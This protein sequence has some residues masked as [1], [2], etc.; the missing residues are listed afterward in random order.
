MMCACSSFDIIH[1]AH[2]D[3]SEGDSRGAGGFGKLAGFGAWVGDHAVER[4]RCDA[5][6]ERLGGC[7]G[8]ACVILKITHALLCSALL[9]HTNCQTLAKLC[10]SPTSIRRLALLNGLK[11]HTIRK[12]RSREKPSH[13]LLCCTELTLFFSTTAF[14]D[15]LLGLR[16]LIYSSPRNWETCLCFGKKNIPAH[17]LLCCTEQLSY[18]FQQPLSLTNCWAC[19]NSYTIV[20]EIGKLVCVLD[21]NHH[22]FCFAA[23]T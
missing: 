23:Q 17:V 11:H 19:F 4:R 3:K 18:L 16:Q 9:H 21:K 22:M 8:A 7:Q 20:H 2:A 6:V 1:P 15:Q 13:A 10:F 14:L 5:L 12:S